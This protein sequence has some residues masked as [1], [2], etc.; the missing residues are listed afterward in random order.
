MFCVK[1]V[2]VKF[3]S[4]VSFNIFMQF[5]FYRTLNDGEKHIDIIIVVVLL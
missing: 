4:V 2:R 3:Y 5:H 1:D